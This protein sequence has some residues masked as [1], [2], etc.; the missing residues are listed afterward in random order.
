MTGTRE[1]VIGWLL[2]AG[3]VL[4]ALWMMGVIGR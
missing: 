4:A 3:M 1:L 2:G